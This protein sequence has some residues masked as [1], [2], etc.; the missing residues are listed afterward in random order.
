MHH[1]GCKT[2]LSQWTLAIP[3]PSTE[4]GEEEETIEEEEANT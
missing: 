4:E 1:G 2:W 3:E